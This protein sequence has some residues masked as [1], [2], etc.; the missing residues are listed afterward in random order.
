MRQSYLNEMRG[1][2]AA[3]AAFLLL[4]AC[5]AKQDA[6][7]VAPP[8]PSGPNASQGP[9]DATVSPSPTSPPPTPSREPG[10]TTLPPAP[11]PP[12]KGLTKPVRVELGAPSLWADVLIWGGWKIQQHFYT[13]QFRLVDPAFMLRAEGTETVCQQALAYLKWKEKARPR[14]RKLALL[15]HGLASSEQIWSPM[16]RA[17]IAGGYEVASI[18]YPSTEQSLSAHGNVL[19]R[20]LLNM[21]KQD[22]DS[23][24]IVAHSLGG[25]VTRTALSRPSFT[26]LP[27]PVTHVVMLGTP[28]RGATM[29][30]W[31]RPLARA[32][33]TATANDLLPERARLVGAIPA[34]VQFGVIAG[35]KGTSIG[36]NPLLAGDDDGVV[37][38]EETQAQNMDGFYRIPVTHMEMAQDSRV[39]AAVR[40][41]LATGRFAAK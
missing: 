40:R 22:F 19:E 30:S 8:A 25:L 20:V 21:D 2:A 10:P 12:A 5:G 14:S 6:V 31:F 26:K 27:V 17:L 34:A 36:F 39:I 3:M 13:G 41:F 24:V 28:N 9:T 11:Q 32:A 33:Y 7:P 23:V 4:S 38:V 29:A 15:I 16:R 35:G 37:K 18:T 1:K